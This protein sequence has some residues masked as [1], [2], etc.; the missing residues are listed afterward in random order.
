MITIQEIISGICWT[1]TYIAVIYR[2]FKDKSYGMPLAALALN[3]AWECTFT[4]V[5]V[6]EQRAAQVVNCIWALFDV[7][8]LITL[9]RYGYSYF[10]KQLGLSKF[11]FAFGI[12][13]AFVFAFAIMIFGAEFFAPLPYFGGEPFEA[14]KMIAMIQNAIMSILFVQLFY[15]RKKQ[16]DGLTGQS[17]W[18]ALTKLVGTSLTVGLLYVF[19]GT[20]NWAFPETLN[21]ICFVFDVWYCILLR[22]ELRSK[23]ISIW[24]RL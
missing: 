19:D 5:Y 24:K 13:N 1:I 4:F 2:G 16:G 3:F 6:P 9:I 22:K 8:I 10:E 18:G 7:G 11:E 23:G 12:G 14:G 17:F 21:A 20:G 15:N